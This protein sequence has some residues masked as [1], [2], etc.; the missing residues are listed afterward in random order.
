MLKQRLRKFLLL[1][2]AALL[3]VL[4]GTAATLV[5]KNAF[6]YD[7]RVDASN[8]LQHVVKYKLNGIAESV[9]IH[10]KING[11]EITYENGKTGYPGT[12]LQDNEVTMPSLVGKPAGKVTYEL[13][14]TTPLKGNKVTVNTPTV[15]K[16]EN[17]TLKN[18]NGNAITNVPN[19]YG[20]YKPF[21][22]AVNN[23]PDSK[24]F[25]QIL[26][27]EGASPGSA[28]NPYHSSNSENK[29]KGRGNSIYAFDPQMQPI[30]NSDKLYGF[31]AGMYASNGRYNTLRFSE[32]GRLFMY[33]YLGTGVYELKTP[34]VDASHAAQLSSGFTK[35][36]TTPTSP[37]TDRPTAFDVWG[38]GSNLRIGVLHTSSYA[39]GVTGTV[40]LSMYNFG[41]KKDA[42]SGNPTYS[43]ANTDTYLQYIQR[44]GYMTCGYDK[45]GNGF[46]VI[47]RVSSPKT[48]DESLLHYNMAS[49]TPE[50]N[51]RDSERTT[52]QF[53]DVCAG[54]F[55]KDRTYFAT[56]TTKSMINVY[57]VTWSNNTPTFELEF[58]KTLSGTNTCDL[59]FDWANNLYVVNRTAEYFTC[60]Q[61]PMPADCT[62]PAPS[63]QAYNRAVTITAATEVTAEPNGNDIDVSWTKGSVSNEDKLDKQIV[64][65][66]ADGGSTW[67]EVTVDANATSYTVA[68]VANGSYL[69]KVRTVASNGDFADSEAV[70]PVDAELTLK[71]S[72][73]K[74]V[75][76]KQTI[77]LSWNQFNRASAYN[78]YCNG[79][80][81]FTSTNKAETLDMPML[82]AK[83]VEYKIVAL[84]DGVES[85]NPKHV[86][87]ATAYYLPYGDITANVAQREANGAV[88]VRVSWTHPAQTN[89][90]K[91]YAI[92][93]APE[94][95]AFAKIAT[96]NKGITEWFDT[97]LRDQ[98][99][100][101]YQYKVVANMAYDLMIG[102]GTTQS[103]VE[104]GI[105]TIDRSL[106]YGQVIID[107]AKTY[108]GYTVAE[109]EW[110]HTGAKPSYYLIYRNGAY[111][112]K[113]NSYSY[114]DSDIPVNNRP[115]SRH[116]YY[117]VGVYTDNGK[118]DGNIVYTTRSEAI[119]L[120]DRVTRE[121]AYNRYGLEVVYNY[122]IFNSAEEAGSNEKWAMGVGT[123]S[124][125]CYSVGDWSKAPGEVYRQGVYKDGYW[126]LS[127]LTNNPGDAVNHKVPS[128]YPSNTTLAEY[129]YLSGVVQI[130]ANDTSLF[131]QHKV[132]AVPRKD[133]NGDIVMKMTGDLLNQSIAID[134]AGRIFIRNAVLG[135]DVT[136]ATSQVSLRNTFARSILYY[137][138][139]PRL[140]WSTT[141]GTAGQVTYGGAPELLNPWSMFDVS[142]SGKDAKGNWN[143]DYT[144]HHRV[145]YLSA[146]S[147]GA[148]GTTRLFAALN[149]TGSMQL[150]TFDPSV[151]GGKVLKQETYSI[152]GIEYAKAQAQRDPNGT[153]TTG[154]LLL[155]DKTYLSSTENYAY[156]IEGRDD[157]IHEIRSAGTFYVDA[158][159]KKYTQIYKS[160]DT[161][162]SGGITFEFNGRLFSLSPTGTVS[163]PTG[164]FRID[165]TH[166]ENIK[167][168]NGNITGV[169]R[170]GAEDFLNMTPVLSFNQTD[171]ATVSAGN[172]SGQWF[173]VEK[174]EANGCIYIYQYVPGVRFAKYR[175][176]DYNEFP[177]VE[178]ELDINVNYT[179]GEET[180]IKNDNFNTDKI[181]HF[182]AT[183]DWKRP[184]H[185]GYVPNPD[186]ELKYYKAELFDSEMN[187]LVQWNQD[188]KLYD[189]EKAY[190]YEQGSGTEYEYPVYRF[191]YDGE[192][193][194]QIINGEE[195]AIPA[196][197][198]VKDVPGVK[199]VSAQTYHLRVTPVYAPRNGG[200]E[201]IGEP[202]EVESSNAFPSAIKYPQVK[203]FV[204]ID[205]DK[206]YRVD[207]DFDL[208]DMM[209]DGNSRYKYEE[210]ADYYTIE[211]STDGGRTFGPVPALNIHY[212]G[213][214]WNGGS[215]DPIAIDQH[216]M[217]GDYRFNRSRHF[218]ANSSK[219][220]VSDHE[221]TN[222]Q[223]GDR[224][225][226]LT[227]DK[228]YSNKKLDEVNKVL[229]QA[230]PCVAYHTFT[231]DKVLKTDADWA[232]YVYRFTA[233]YATDNPYI[234]QTASVSESPKGKPVQTGISDVR[235]D[236]DKD[237]EGSVKAYPIPARTTLTVSGS[238][239]LQKLEL[240]NTSGALVQSVKGNG[241][242]Q[243]TIRVADLPAGNY[244][245]RVNGKHTLHI[246]K[247]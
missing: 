204:D 115:D 59:A 94:G 78:I 105:S 246:I 212:N 208:D 89:L 247:H 17:T 187:R 23:A 60:L 193:I 234:Y 196:G 130:D 5:Q 154:D 67:T 140:A 108:P 65:Y 35:I 84:F 98:T 210:P 122:P 66:S 242:T 2:V 159:T 113:V 37:G 171:F 18:A 182:D 200:A 116:S 114:I 120:T 142:I 132:Q 126:Y 156:P 30:L 119:T 21:S 168:E 86:S 157:F 240:F 80:L 31:V 144:Q 49:G 125:L 28:T 121:T 233:H 206:F 8:K 191:I 109:L 106:T 232:N 176:F 62:V 58:Q 26:V 42:W 51:Y 150:I 124:N 141:T 4:T 179:R 199:N 172:S 79:E 217:Q 82:N 188:D 128:S 6:A 127:Q 138:G 160:S 220:M 29:G 27:S 70:K 181:T 211:W 146:D 53:T 178:P 209:A 183:F 47:G 61:L 88:D 164:H 44:P 110:H 95:G 216:C 161:H 83:A 40:T 54:V 69:F 165:L 205:N 111:T 38:S 222:A 136:S 227:I 231:A 134:D 213:G 189:Q 214:V 45:D 22:V 96:V 194:A 197:N 52:K 148:N 225:P 177:G 173:G 203:A 41:T 192:S 77:K 15:T 226:D 102:S 180:K 90:V 14:V 201:I 221:A 91:D 112:D 198:I 33:C 137:F 133:G 202:G 139:L 103:S 20:F 92:Y 73:Q 155:Y 25:G 143:W 55:N 152:D 131:E 71:L 151:S 236:G 81:V 235:V 123:L 117:I 219:A 118:A 57:S 72:A 19:G 68:G 238:V 175:L 50:M 97:S 149:R 85:E 243:Q 237:G 16:D 229:D 13:V 190:D 3:S 129:P 101:Q 48:G 228:A 63:S 207:L 11:K 145:H 163:N 93:R 104:S 74:W 46:T 64:M 76:S 223:Y 34:S 215:D 239:I 99:T 43:V 166:Q 224:K 9:V 170:N 12:T 107:V 167:D 218:Q 32:D 230:F 158:K 1:W 24:S 7:I 100:G 244:V 147:R 185:Y 245:L 36:I 186:Y 39:D 174:D 87:T 135:S 195:Y 10:T 169:K 184:D 241:T 153:H 75:D 56:A 162:G